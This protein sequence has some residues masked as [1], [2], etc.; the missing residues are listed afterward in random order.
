MDMEELSV[1]GE[2][3][4]AAKERALKLFL[5]VSSTEPNCRHISITTLNS[6]DLGF[7]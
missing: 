2:G 7:H 5:V 6:M 4:A 3:I 1:E